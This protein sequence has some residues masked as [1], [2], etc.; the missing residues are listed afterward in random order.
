MSQTNWNDFTPVD[1]GA[2][3]PQASANAATNWDDFTPAPET[4]ARGFKGWARDVAATATK[5]AIGVP[6]LAVGLADIPT[7]GRVGKFL[8]NEGGAVGFRPKQAKEIVNEWH[9][10]ATKE[11]QRKFQEA[12]G[13]VDK[14]ATAIQNPSLIATAVGESLGPMGAG[15]VA[16]R[17]LMA[18]TRL[19][20]MGAKGA[21]LAGAAGEG[22]AMAGSAAEQIRQETDDGLLTPTQ[23]GIAAATGVAG[24]VLGVGGAKLAQRLGVGDADTMLAQGMKG[25]NRQNADEAATAA[26]NPL[27]Q[28]QA[29]KSIPRS[30][31]EGAISEGLFEE[32]PQSVTEQVLQNIALGKDWHQD[33]DAAVVMGA[34]S[35][36]AM[37]GA[38]AGYR[39]ATRPGETEAR[40]PAPPAVP[41]APGQPPQ[42]GPVLGLPAPDRGVIQVAGDGTARTPAYQ[43][44]GYVGDVTD[45]EPK[46]PTVRDQVATA[47]AQ[48][49]ALSPAALTAID[50]GAAAAAQPVEPVPGPAAP[51]SLEEADA[52]DR[53]AYEQFFVSADAEP[54]VARYFENDNDIPDFDAAS[55]V[56]D[57]DFL[58]ALGATDE[59]IQDAIATTSQPA[60][61]QGSAAVNAGAQANEPAGTGQGAGAVAAGQEGQ[62]A[63]RLP[64][65]F[66]GTPT[67]TMG[68]QGATARPGP[69]FGLKD[70]LAQIRTR[71]KQEAAN[72]KAATPEAAPATTAVSA[73]RPGAVETAGVDRS[74]LLASLDQAGAT[75]EMVLD[76]RLKDAQFRL[77][78]AIASPNINRADQEAEVRS[79]NQE[80]ADLTNVRSQARELDERDRREGN[81]RSMLQGA[82][83]ELDAAVR[84]G[85]VTPDAAQSIAADAQKTGNAADAAEAVFAAVD[86]AAAAAGPAPDIKTI[87]A[88]QIPDMTDGELQAA[89]AHYG[90]EHKRTA[91]L[92]KEVQ[93]RAAQTTQGSTNATQTAQ[94]K[95]ASSKPA[96]AGAAPAAAAAPGQAGPA[97]PAGASTVRALS[98]G[99]P[100]QNPGAQSSTAAGAQAQAQ[101]AAPDLN[102]A[103]ARWTRMTRL[104][105]EAV[106]K[107]AGWRTNA[108]GLNV[109]GKR[110]VMTSWGNM[111]AGTQDRV[112]RAMS[113]R[114]EFG[115][116]Q[117]AAPA[118]QAQAATENVATQPVDSIF[119]GKPDAKNSA[120]LDELEGFKAGDTV[121][122]NGRTIGRSTIEMVYRRQMAGFGMMPM[123]RVVGADGKKLDVLL[124]D[125]TRVE[126]T[127]EATL[128]EQLKQVNDQLASQGQVQNANTRAKRDQIR[129]AIAERDFPAILKAVDGD[130]GSAEAINQALQFAGDEPRAKVIERV[131]KNRGI[132][133]EYRQRWAERLMDGQVDELDAE[134]QSYEDKATVSLRGKAA[135]EMLE[136]GNGTLYRIA[137]IDTAANRIRLVRNPDQLNERTVLVDQDGYNKLLADHEQTM[138]EAMARVPAPA[139]SAAPQN[140]SANPL[141]QAAQDSGKLEVVVVG[142]KKPAAT[143]ANSSPDDWRNTLMKT[144][145]HA[146]ALIDAG[147]LDAQAA[148]AVWADHEKLLALVDGGVQ[149]KQE[150]QAPKAKPAPKKKPSADQTRAKADLMAALADLGDI[151]G[152]NTRMNITPEQEVKLLPVLTRVLDAAFRLGYHKFKDSAKFALDQIR[153]NLGDEAADALTLDHLQGAYIAMAGG[154]DGVDT[155]RAV[156]DV[157]T[158][159]EIEAHEVVDPDS[160]TDAPV[161]DAP[162]EKA[163]TE[164]KDAENVTP[165]AT[166]QPG[167]PT[168]APGAGVQDGKPG[169]VRGNAGAVRGRN[170][171]PAAGDAGRGPAANA[172]ADYVPGPQ[173]LTRTGSWFE[174]AK[175]NIDLIEL[176]IKIDAEKRPATPQEQEQLSK[177]VGF[178]ASAIRNDLFPIPH[179]YAKRQEPNRLIWPNLVR[180]ARWKPLAERIEALPREW[181]QSILQ[182]SQYAHYTSEGIIRSV[183]SALD[184]MGFKGGNVFEP[185]MGIGSFAMLMPNDVRAQSR[186]TGIEFDAPTALIAGLLSPQQNMI[187]GDFIQRKFPKN[188]F[189]VNVGN[190]P[191]SQTKI[192]GDPEYAKKG[193]MLH[194]FFFAKGIDLVRPGGI[195]VFV[196]SKGTMDKQSDK[197]RKYLSERADLLGAIR[198][199]S[200]AFEG[201]AGTSVVTDVIFLK[202]RAPGEAPGGHPWSKVATVETPDGP[203][204][205]NEYF[206]ANPHMVLGQ[207]R[208]S[209]N[210]DDEGRRINSNG[211]GGEK[212]TVVSYDK[213]PAELDAKFA[214]AV[215]K[216]PAGAY[217]PP[218]ANEA[219]A[220]PKA[221]DFDPAVKREGVIY[222]GKDGAL[223]R[224]DEGVGKP[225]AGMV[226]LSEKEQAWFKGYV[227]LRDKV[228]AARFD[229]LNDGPWEKS[230]AALNKAYDAFRKEHGPVK[231]FRV[232]VRKST[233]EDGKIIG[234]ESR[235]FK[236]RKLYR[237]DYDNALITSLEE[238]TEDGDIVK[239]PFLKG[240]T[241]GK[242]VE[243][244]VRSIGDA[245]AVS[246]DEIGSLSLEDVGR[247]LGLSREE[248]IEA[249]GDQVYLTPT[250]EWQLADEYLSGDVVAKLEEAEEAARL[251]PELRR[252]VQALKDVQPEKLGPSQISAKLGAS[253]VPESHVNEF[254]AEI[255]AGAVTFDPRTET[256]QVDGGNLRSQR[257]AGDEYGTAARSPSELLEAVLN[258]RSIKVA[259]DSKDGKDLAG[260]VN[261]A[262]TTAANETAKKIKDKFKGWVWTDTDRS[263][264]L[265]ERYNKQFN[266]IAP[267]RF[268]GSHLTLP[269]VSLRFKL[270][271]HQL[272]AIWRMVQ[273]GNTYLAH[274]VGAGKTIEMIAGGMEQKRLGL[275]KKP[276]Y[277]VPNH[278]LEQFSNEFM[279]LYPMANIMVAD[280]ENFS[281]ERRKAFVAAATLN[282][283]DAIVITHDAFQR[284]GVKEESVAPIRDE[285]LADLEI[286][287]AETAKGNDTRVRRSQLEQQ[288]E[289]VKQRFDRIIGAGAK[290]STVKFEDMGV[291]FVFADEAHV[292]RKLDFHTAQQI[293]GIDPNGSKRALDMYVKTRILDGRNPGRSMVFASGTPV[294]NTMGELYTIMR[295]FAGDALDKA[296][297][298]TFD[299]W[300]R[301]FGEVVPALEPNAAGKYE[302]IERFAKFDNVPEL[303]SRVRQFM[304][305]LTSDNLGALVKRPDIKGGKPNLNITE[306]NKALKEYMEGELARRIEISKAWKPSKDEPANPDPIVAIITDGRFAALDPRFFGG[307]LE[308]GETSLLMDMGK[309]VVQSYHSTKNNV[310]QDKA[311]KDEPIKGST[312]LVFYN[313]GFGEQSQK[314]RGF[315]SRAAFTKILTDGGIP[316]SEIYWFDDANTD[317]KKEAVFK[318]VRNGKVKVLIGSAKKMGTGVNV[319]K[320]LAVLHYQDPPWFPADV[321]QPHGRIIRQGNQNAEGAIEWYTTKGTY[322]STMWQMVGRKQRF[323]DQAFTGDKN[324]RSM[325]DLGEASLFEQAAAVAS[326]D[327]RA[328]QLAGLRQDVERFERLQASH[329]SEQ[330]NVASSLRS[331]QWGVDSAKKRIATY[332][333]AFAA[334]GE[335]YFAFSEGKVGNATYTKPGEFG[336]AIKDAF[337]KTAADA[338]MAEKPVKDKPIAA[339]GDAITIYMDEGVSEGKGDGQFE[340]SVSF[341]GMNL[342]LG[343]SSGMGADVDATGLARRIFNQINSVDQD[344]RKAKEDLARNEVDINKLRKK[345]GAPFEYQQEMAEKYAELKRL[346]AELKAEGQAPATPAAPT[347]TT[348]DA[349]TPRAEGESTNRLQTGA[350][351]ANTADVLYSSADA[352]L[353]AKPLS[354]NRVNQLV[355][356]ALSGIRG[357][358]PVEVTARPGDIGLRVPAGSVG[359]GVTL[360]G[361]DIYV[362]QSA[363][364]SDLDVFKTVFHELFHRG[365]RVLVPK[366]QYVQ[367]MLDLAKGDSRIQQLAIEWKN[368]EMGQ[369]QKDNLRKQGY[370]GAELTGQYEALAIEEALA[371]VAE[372]IKAEGKLGS[373]PKSMTIRYLANWLAKL[374]DMAGMKKLAQGIRAMTY[375][376][377]ERFVMSAIDRS[378]E[379][380][381]AGRTDN[382]STKDGAP[383]TVNTMTEDEARKQGFTLKAYRGISKSNPFND[384]G[385]T[386]L[387]T[388]REVAEAYAEEVMGYD[389]PGVLEVMVKPD[390]L[391]RH[392]ASRLTDEQR[393]AF[394][395]DEF[396]NPQSM[397]I[398]DKSDDHPL[399]GSRG[400]V[401]VIHAPREAVAVL[402]NAVPAASRAPAGDQTQTEAFKRWFG[403]SKVVDAEG[404]PLVAYHGTGADIQQFNVSERGE[405][406]G[407]IY[408]TP[409]TTGASDYAMYRGQG[410]ANVM[411]VYVAIRNPAGAAEASQV[412]SW[413]GEENAQAELIRRGYDGVIDMRS[414]QIVAFRPEQIKSA[415]GNN[416][417]FDPDT[418][419]IRFRS[420]DLRSLKDSAID[421]LHQTL[422]HP[423]KVSLWDR[424]VGTMRHLSERNPAF[425]PVFEA[426]QRFIDDVAMLANDAA[427]F[428][429]RLLPRVESWRDLRKSPISAQDNKAV[430]RPL[431]DGTLLWG[432]DVDGK[433][434]LVRDLESKYANL[435][436]DDKAQMMLKA[437]RIDPGVLKMWRGLP[438]D[439]YESAVNTRFS[440]TLLKAGVVWTDQELKDLFQAT[441]E[442]ASLYREARKAIDRSIDMT[443]RADMLR[444]LGEPYAPMR[445]VVLEAPTLTDAMTLLVESLEQDA[446]E[447]PD[448]RDRL[449]GLMH[450][451]RQRQEKAAELMAQGYAPLSRFGRYT[452]DVVD[453]AGERQYFGMFETAREANQ[454]ALRMRSTFQGAKVTQGTMSQEAYKLFAGITP[455]S[456]EMF[457][458]MLGL[459]SEGSDAQ[460]KAFQEYLRLTKNNHSALKR[461]IHRQGIAGYSE[462]VGRVLASFVYSN[463][464]QAAGA[465]N[466]GTMERAIGNIPKEQGELKDVAMGLQS[467]IR[468]PQE[469]GQ[470]IRGMLFAQYLG[471]SVA[472]AFVNMTQPFQITL[473]WLSQYGGIKSAGAQMARAV[474]DM[475]RRGHKYEADLAQALKHAEDDG[476]VSPQELHQIM[477]Q[478]RGSGSLR[479]GDGTRV[480]DLRA[481]AGNQ[482]EKTKVL[483]GQPFALAEQFNRRSTFIAAYRLA[484]EQGKANPAEFARRAVLETQFLYSKANKP[485][486]ARGAIGGTVFTF[487]T[488]SVSYL[489]LMHRMWTQG[490]P[491]GKRAVGWAVAMLLLMGGAGG[492]P[493][494]EDA[495]DLIDGAGQ[496]MGHNVSTKQWRMALLRDVLGKE[497]ASFVEQG[498]SG[499]PGAPVDV[500]GRLGMGNL[501]P[502]TGLF[503]DKPNR[504][505][506]MTELV[507]PA[508]DLISRGFTGA[509][510]ALTGDLA[511]AALEVSPVAVRNM[512]KGA[513]MAASGIY[514]DTKGYTVIDTTLDEA[515][516]KAI[517]FQPKS[518]AQVQE[519]AGFMQRSRSFYVK[520]SSEIKAQWAQALFNKDEAALEDVRERLAAWNR[521]NPEQRIVV[522]MPYVWKR[523]RE[524]GKDRNQR[525]A[526]TAPKALREQMRNMARENG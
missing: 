422:S 476:V 392:D 53:A 83:Q 192:Y 237:E 80:I 466:A 158:K 289:A 238:I 315:N 25:I 38:A 420:A 176:A 469:E 504:T 139:P 349:L 432:R 257:T 367:T 497:L 361:G 390:G 17:G 54:V 442:Q 213:T 140:Q 338:V 325:D 369:K 413:K 15:A 36:G 302:L 408:L 433:P 335:R 153:A 268:D 337:N 388:S 343:V 447:N 472:S 87:T 484:K 502:G 118:Q 9:S 164:T 62:V 113:T 99:A 255:G 269:G 178:G 389:D 93:R 310:Y 180:D 454:M 120:A 463:A 431:F 342:G 277:V 265:V 119:T 362:F 503:L 436:A 288:I 259:Y 479:A 216:L 219:K 110:L 482:W 423:G 330:I 411:P 452:V 510:K 446:R 487:K 437:G 508:G 4:P 235:I 58:R 523:V 406:G 51:I 179:D 98:N 509:R 439:Q 59:D 151:L 214:A 351:E 44:P 489:E 33:V 385:T 13:I 345:L 124:S 462:D 368:T 415:I 30:V 358:P 241:I 470:A 391:P 208:I 243:R 1:D 378:G 405:F 185:G 3:A 441:P 319:Q 264:E 194:D 307:K 498:V 181:Q 428:A 135:G 200:T 7:G 189:D 77:R 298:S 320:R 76:T 254:A 212:Y 312:Q 372:E 326:G 56:S 43:T 210:V 486:W 126:A 63:P 123:A 73:A 425:K 103:G 162:E 323:I 69:G 341:G 318:D 294:T 384:S 379:P 34:L 353:P 75:R 49:G 501:I 106:L 363:M 328:I 79:L 8:E 125:L 440:N 129:K 171:Q 136:M 465:L 458:N 354:L 514:K 206:A 488:Y 444:L 16:A 239:A 228:Q 104:E 242:P 127:A 184:R 261:P 380:V 419:D 507:G 348:D 426:A 157:E 365:V 525:I 393:E 169:K 270:H 251:Q 424:T 231:D 172:G 316:R 278:M 304:D 314:T 381:Q 401:T 295:F 197:A 89:I 142:D 485:R 146:K 339:I 448:D 108:G 252:N 450:G 101:G 291:D 371:A 263:T 134:M 449:A 159:A 491:E 499:L 66:T 331:A 273:T 346:E 296:G 478:A 205:V 327:P 211:M 334:I 276:M 48:G 57:E 195:Q 350:P 500:S 112:A 417:N 12:D 515:L 144:R 168:V 37:G 494:M 267:R 166:T 186:Y 215:Q 45:V 403:G 253:W 24:A 84:A 309:G 71:K 471:G 457:G 60:S 244:V 306:P 483:W 32:L 154:K 344:L 290:D 224:V 78:Q 418:A 74:K 198:L 394:G 492:L 445:D 460:D 173:G 336:Q 300:A 266:N 107:L 155:K 225:L 407:G 317:A 233:D 6:E 357:A 474:K 376:E 495:E 364:G 226:S 375:N 143:S 398:Y 20:Q 377:A 68:Q 332:T 114:A 95:Q 468:D 410:P 416:G 260:K 52:R 177:Y 236:N 204:V 207:Q 182:S 61:P 311:G 456:L 397:G 138:A 400:N 187:H 111:V 196:T 35:G 262:A 522:K 283:P 161:V 72:A 434:V 402:R 26:T 115:G 256:W 324:L 414:G 94:A 55:N 137:G 282:N 88:K 473:P 245:L 46:A 218:A 97:T 117:V 297:I 301:Q 249:L 271:P 490:G 511:G 22:A 280:D 464:R 287:L 480:G 122:V 292:F 28:Q 404:K 520:T 199:P 430:A 409:D 18:A 183:W 23:S 149:S 170:P 148:Q 333:K 412:A 70:A 141:M 130:V 293:K 65:N 308:E 2:P 387:T 201:N 82:R 322:Q 86:S 175:R 42:P 19:G 121:E 232:Q 355:Q 50:T 443:S 47:A 156:I 421:Q 27:V 461:L 505:R 40:A 427:E 321:E 191:F 209:G 81:T 274:A 477:A 360:R 190:P 102:D 396:G 340:L 100:A 399:G 286:E 152:K 248:A 240:R 227:A 435:S 150:A 275:I 513:D 347:I 519:A 518:V 524:M 517:G 303:M 220:K 234:V 250:G 188:F 370:T 373:K 11:A 167:Q 496:L 67:A 284:I 512:A 39:S 5:A 272:R 147:K 481:K 133:E 96:Q 223:M 438:L 31:I 21:A 202:K 217:A 203:V 91:K 174:T 163:D 383:G 128:D 305:V 222:L 246:L 41:P 493:F 229:Q 10:D 516:S 329:A 313:L 455:E 475:A 193:F 64:G 359:Y 366:A 105:R 451:L 299:A 221:V 85:A 352:D 116:N 247:R 285:I 165:D 109:V 382:M 386:W 160:D 281:P 356:E 145:A 395:A 279:E 429:P 459:D 131:L 230:L 90:P 453:A 29:A 467:Y 374:A 132:S 506:D 14:A 526:E 521:N 258:S 92:Q